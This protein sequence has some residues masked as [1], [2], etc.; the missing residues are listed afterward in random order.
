MR[1][2]MRRTLH[3]AVFTGGLFAVGTGIA[4]AEDATTSGVGGVGSGNQ[5]IAPVTAP[6]TVCGNSAAV[7]GH[8]T[9]TC[10]PPAAAPSGDTS[11]TT[12]GRHGVLSGNQVLAP[13]TAPITVAGNAIGGTARASATPAPAGTA[14]ATGTDTGS[15]TTTGRHGI[16]SG[17]QVITPITAPV[18]VCGNAI[19]LL[20][21][22]TAHCT[23]PATPG[24]S[25][26]P[27]TAT[28]TGRHGVGS[29]NQVIT[30]ITAPVDVCGNAIAL[31]GHA[32][33]HCTTPT[34]GSGGPTSGSTSGTGGVGSGNQVIIPITAPVDVCG[35]AVAVLGRSTAGCTPP[36]PG[37][38]G[39]PGN[40]GGPGTPGNPGGPGT[41]GQ[42][43]GPGSGAGTGS[44]TGVGNGTG[45]G[46]GTAAPVQEAALTNTGYGSA[47]AAPALAH[48]GT[49]PVGELLLLAALLLLS[50]AASLA[51][52]RLA[53]GRQH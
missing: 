27:T 43:G 34:P 29:G 28:T 45:A 40:P 6:V 32:T 11:A 15:A 4:H 22:A 25:G 3:A 37:T 13:V 7:L 9:A 23:T 30:P 14:P 39:G 51:V 36:C 24:D 50:G 1:T 2:W 44:S 35:N 41:P 17:N 16:A 53:I 8:A 18:D 52:R 49:T 38:P 12:S 26:S 20:G 5:I 19:A 47:T 33:A 21:R 48:T 46:A 31:L 10:Q 42:P